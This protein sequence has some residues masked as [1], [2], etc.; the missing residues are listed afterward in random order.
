MKVTRASGTLGFPRAHAVSASSRDDETILLYEDDQALAGEI[1]LAFEAYG[2]RVD[3]LPDEAMLRAR[4]R[5]GAAVLVLDR[6]VGERDSVDVLAELRAAGD[7]T[8]VI[9]ISSLASVDDR[10]HG[11]KVGGDDYL[12][13]PFAMGELV[14]RTAALRRRARSDVSTT[15]RVDTL[16]M[17]LIS[18]KVRRGERDVS[19]LPREFTLLEYLMRHA[20]DIVTRAM[21]LEEV[22]HYRSSTQTNVVDVH[23][24][25][26]RRKIEADGEERLLV[27]VRG[28][29]FKLGTGAKPA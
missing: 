15:L 6:M 9:V 4:V 2:L 13:K 7:R 16:A 29:G 23:V 19:L 25:N 5:R 22:W 17:D 24:G 27:N 10:I 14:A 20:G 28:I 3:V 12:V 11:L 21:L 1:I 8:P 18:R 26:L